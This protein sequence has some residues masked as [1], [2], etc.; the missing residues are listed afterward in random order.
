MNSAI[1]WKN[2]ALAFVALAFVLSS[3]GFAYGVDVAGREISRQNFREIQRDSFFPRTEKTFNMP[4]YRKHFEGED[5]KKRVL[6]YLISSARLYRVS[7][8]AVLGAFMGEHSMNQRSSAKQAGESGIN[9]IGK[10]FGSSGESVVNALN[11]TFLGSKG[12]AS[13][14]P[15]QIQPFIAV[16]MQSE[17]KKTRPEATADELDKYNWLGAINIICAYMNYAAMK[18]EKEGFE[19]RDDAPLL[20]TLFNIGERSKTFEKRVAE[21]K[22]LIASGERE[23]LWLNYFGYWIQKNHK[24]LTE[25][26]N[27][28]TAVP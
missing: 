19:V 9:F 7:P 20:V 23:R 26:I 2:L 13:F 14:G 21:T 6:N 15:G 27:S 25:K 18:Y 3:G 17:I 10:K 22:A 1:R 5:G 24:I 28:G 16:A 8:E 11:V 12:A 4:F